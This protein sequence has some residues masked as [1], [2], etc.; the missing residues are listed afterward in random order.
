MPTPLA[1][2]W[3][4]GPVV[5]STPARVPVLGMTRR[6][7]A[8]LAE[9]LEVVEAEVVAGQVE[10]GV[11]QHAR[12]AG[13][14]HEAVAVRPRRVG[15]VVAEVPREQRVR[16]G[17]RTHGH[18]GV[19]GVGLLDAVDGE[20]ADGVDAAVFKGLCARH[21]A[22]LVLPFGSESPSASALPR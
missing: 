6:P 13:R 14:Q 7:A 1:T 18:A 5:V 22:H 12:V 8:P 4:S 21:W 19:A 10:Q 3:P 9:R 15:G 20:K 11:Q 16:D 2:P 17:R